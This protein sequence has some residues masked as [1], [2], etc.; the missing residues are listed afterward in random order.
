MTLF[1]MYFEMNWYAAWLGCTVSQNKYS[2]TLSQ[3]A[4]N[5]LQKGPVSTNPVPQQPLFVS[6]NPI[7]GKKKKYITDASCDSVMKIEA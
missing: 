5:A 2:K 3:T 6:V 1:S 4:V 7:Y